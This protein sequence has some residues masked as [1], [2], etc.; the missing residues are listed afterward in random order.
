MACA[1]IE[2]LC[3]DE[4]ND[5]PI[6]LTITDESTGNPI[7]I[8]GYTFYL[9]I[10]RNKSDTDAAAIIQKTKSDPHTDPTN[11]ITII[12]ID[13]A[14]TLDKSGDYFYDIVMDDTTPDRTTIL[15]GEFLIQQ[16]IGDN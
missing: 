12:E 10:K 13:K 2:N 1:K 3:M 14:D 6:E 11:G 7:D 8:T 5:F 4:H 16:A 15:T 9:T